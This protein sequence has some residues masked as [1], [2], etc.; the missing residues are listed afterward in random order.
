MKKMEYF[1]LPTLFLYRNYNRNENCKISRVKSE[2]KNI[3]LRFILA[4][5]NFEVKSKNKRLE[6]PGR[7][8]RT[9]PI[10]SEM[11]IKG[12]KIFSGMISW[13]S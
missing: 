11:R 2:R 3:R 9:F 6:E 4:W 13:N 8:R 1:P 10:F 12:E 5:S 7:K